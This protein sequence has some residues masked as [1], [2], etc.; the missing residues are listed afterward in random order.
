MQIDELV[1]KDTR[2]RKLYARCRQVL[3]QF[4]ELALVGHTTAAC[5]NAGSQTLNYSHESTISARERCSGCF[6]TTE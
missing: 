4:R 1:C 6:V 5:F 3:H 2:K